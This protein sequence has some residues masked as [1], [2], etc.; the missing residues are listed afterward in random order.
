MKQTTLLMVALAI[1][2]AATLL[3]RDSDAHGKK[4]VRIPAVL[5]MAAI[6]LVSFAIH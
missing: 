4:I 6:M 2:I 3:T 1:G 5:A